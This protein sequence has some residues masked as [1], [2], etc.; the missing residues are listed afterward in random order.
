MKED[1]FKKNH[2]TPNQTIQPYLAPQSI[3]TK[4]VYSL[5]DKT[6]KASEEGNN[7]EELTDL[8][9]A[10]ISGNLDLVTSLIQSGFSASNQVQAG[11][12]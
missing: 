9:I 2:H 1:N 12:Y 5:A 3:F 7:P 8:H 10:A 6:A 4:T 11:S